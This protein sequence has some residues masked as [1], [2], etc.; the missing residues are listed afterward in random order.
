ML[1]SFL[2]SNRAASGDALLTVASSQMLKLM[3]H[4]LLDALP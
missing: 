2:R 3:L 1:S 4:G